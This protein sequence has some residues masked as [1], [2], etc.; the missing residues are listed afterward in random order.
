MGVSCHDHFACVA[1]QVM[2]NSAV[3][4]SESGDVVSAAVRQVIRFLWIA[5]LF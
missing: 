3:A 1:F 4:R 2:G 5:F